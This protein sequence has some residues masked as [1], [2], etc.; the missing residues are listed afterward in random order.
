MP[1]YRRDGFGWHA[2]V[3]QARPKSTAERMESMP[4]DALTQIVP[5]TS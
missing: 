1:K 5:A 4:F 2:I 3:V